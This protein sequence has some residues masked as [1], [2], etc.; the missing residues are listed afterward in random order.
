M[1]LLQIGQQSS[2]CLAKLNKTKAMS[3][4]QR[5]LTKVQ[6]RLAKFLSKINPIEVS[7]RN[8]KLT[9]ESLMKRRRKE[10]V[11]PSLL[12]S[13]TKASK[14]KECVKLIKEQYPRLSTEEMI[15]TRA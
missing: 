15:E 14:V 1:T 4:S 13:R 3:V 7:E 6:C 12:E 2:I 5:F 11:K 10:S 9:G 8:Q